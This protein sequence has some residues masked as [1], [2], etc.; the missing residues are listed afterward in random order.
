MVPIYTR[1]FDQVHSITLLTVTSF[2]L[3]YIKIKK[4]EKIPKSFSI[5]FEFCRKLLL[6][7]LSWKCK[8]FLWVILIQ[9]VTYLN[10]CSLYSN[11]DGR[12]GSFY[13]WP[14][15]RE[16]FTCQDNSYR[17]S[18]VADYVDITSIIKRNCRGV[19]CLVSRNRTRFTVLLCCSSSFEWIMSVHKIE[20]LVSHDDII[21]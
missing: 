6:M 20:P 2:Q 19:A 8:L 13:V 5:M 16:S 10:L 12:D 17:Y 14:K 4:L 15:Y 11:I 9:S 3:K 1:F 7:G 21:T 18:T